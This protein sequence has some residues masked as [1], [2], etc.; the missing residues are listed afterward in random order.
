MFPRFGT[1]RCCI[2]LGTA[3][4]LLCSPRNSGGPKWV[5]PRL[6]SPSL[7]RPARPGTNQNTKRPKKITAT[8]FSWV[9]ICFCVP[10]C[11]LP[12]QSSSGVLICG[13]FV[14]FSLPS[15]PN[16][17]LCFFS[18]FAALNTD[19][20]QIPHTREFESVLL[21]FVYLPNRSPAAIGLRHAATPHTRGCRHCQCGQRNGYRPQCI[22]H[23]GRRY[24][25]LFWRTNDQRVNADFT[26]PCAPLHHQRSCPAVSRH[27]LPYDKPRTRRERANFPSR[28]RNDDSTLFLGD[29]SLAAAPTPKLHQRGLRSVIK[30]VDDRSL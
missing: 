3:A 29:G 25:Y 18:P 4:D 9:S 1:P 20:Y 28:V 7:W 12:D 2:K 30:V 17:K 11:R 13:H 5:S 22:V 16:L 8:S 15:F 23:H 6:D 10:T 19:S 21:T 27:P 26:S 24:A 14:L